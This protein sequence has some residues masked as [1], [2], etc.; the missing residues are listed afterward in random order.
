MNVTI[1][2]RSEPPPLPTD[3]ELKAML[4]PPVPDVII[5]DTRTVITETKVVFIPVPLFGILVL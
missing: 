5:I 4:P 1:P 3:D 2:Y